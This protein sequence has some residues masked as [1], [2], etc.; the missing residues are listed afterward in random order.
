MT[1]NAMYRSI[2]LVIALC[3]FCLLWFCLLCI[4]LLACID[5][6]KVASA[7][8]QTEG[9]NARFGIFSMSHHWSQSRRE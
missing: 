7:V 3:W 4:L 8:A 6:C 1:V 2:V 5:C 9:R